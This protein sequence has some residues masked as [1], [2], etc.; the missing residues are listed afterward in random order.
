MMKPQ[1]VNVNNSIFQSSN[2]GTP[3]MKKPR[4]KQQVQDLDVEML[5]RSNQVIL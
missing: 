2:E 4:P 5:A 3:A 1:H